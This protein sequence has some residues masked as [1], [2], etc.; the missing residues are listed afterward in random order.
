MQNLKLTVQHS[1]SGT[2]L[3]RDAVGNAIPESPLE[4]S[5]V[6][7]MLNLCHPYLQSVFAITDS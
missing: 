1:L 6:Q 3:N 4:Q 2:A 7:D 5:A